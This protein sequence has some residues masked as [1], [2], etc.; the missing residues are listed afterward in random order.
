MDASAAGGPAA[1]KLFQRHKGESL[2]SLPV[3][4]REKIERLSCL[5]R[6][7]NAMEVEANRKRWEALEAQG[8]YRQ[9]CVEVENFV[10]EQ[11][12]KVS[13]PETDANTVRYY[14]HQAR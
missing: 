7:R 5:V 14:G 3:T 11:S 4:E 6:K 12:N 9:A 10:A 13:E 8:R 2:G 1:R